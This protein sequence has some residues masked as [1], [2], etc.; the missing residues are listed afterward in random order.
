MV[1]SKEALQ[2]LIE[3]FL[4]SQSEPV[5][6]KSM[7]DLF[8]R[9][10][11]SVEVLDVDIHEL[12]TSIQQDYAMRGIRLCQV[13]G[14]WQFRTAEEWASYLVKVISKPKRLSRAAM[15]TLAIIAY[16]QPCT[17]ADIERIR[18]VTLGQPILDSLLEHALVK[19]CGHRQVPGRPTLWGTTKDFL[20]YL[21]LDSLRDLPKKEELIGEVPYQTTAET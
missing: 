19:P 16:H 7:M 4:F 12:L 18:G 17:R 15:E 20:T 10:S 11:I 3:A 13:A 8:E 9:N 5:S 21:G 14:G 1:Q 6:E 2:T